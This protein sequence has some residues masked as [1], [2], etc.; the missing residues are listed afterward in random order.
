MFY[1]NKGITYCK[2]YNILYIDE[3]KFEGTNW[4]IRNR[5]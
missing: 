2:E 3:E 5:K 1:N 4:V